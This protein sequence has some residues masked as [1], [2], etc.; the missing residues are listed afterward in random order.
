VLPGMVGAAGD[1]GC[2]WVGWVLLVWQVLLVWRVLLV[3]QVLLGWRVLPVWRVLP[4][5]VGA[6]GLVECWWLWVVGAAGLVECCWVVYCFPKACDAAGLA[7]F[8]V[9]GVL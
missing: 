4:G 9:F 3:W 5:I 8:E 2:C 7:R 1:G 6:A